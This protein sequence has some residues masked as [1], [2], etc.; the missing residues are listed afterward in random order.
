MIKKKIVSIAAAAIAA[1]SICATAYATTSGVP[2]YTFGPR[3]LA[4]YRNPRTTDP[5][6]K[7]D[8][9]SAWVDVEEGLSNGDAYVTFRVYES[10][11]GTPVATPAV[12]TWINGERYLDYYSGMGVNGNKYYLQY[13]MEPQKVETVY[14][15][16]RWAP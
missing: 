16:G 11:Q 15:G 7:E 5:V 8:N 2:K 1:C 4:P 6:K 14:I 13:Y 10:S 12:D 3:I 9:I